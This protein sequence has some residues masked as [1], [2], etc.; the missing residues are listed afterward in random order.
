MFSIYR[1][2][3]HPEYTKPLLD[4]AEAMLKLPATDHYKHLP[5]M[6]SFLRETARHD[7]LDSCTLL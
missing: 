5:L 1:L 3:E 2:C 6:E 4:E 7:P